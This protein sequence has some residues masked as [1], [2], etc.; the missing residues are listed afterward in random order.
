MSRFIV[1]I[2]GLQF[3]RRQLRFSGDTG[4]VYEVDFAK[5]G[6][7]HRPRPYLF[8]TPN[9]WVAWMRVDHSPAV[10]KS[11]DLFRY[12]APHL[13]VGSTTLTSESV[14]YYLDPNFNLPLPFFY[15]ALPPNSPLQVR[16]LL[17]NQRL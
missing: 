8:G 3:F 1:L 5:K 4:D 15:L 9:H 13:I 14:Y 12:Y 17:Q 7:I 2:P 11:V 16:E 10:G 6:R